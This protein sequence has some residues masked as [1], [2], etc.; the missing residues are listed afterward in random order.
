MYSVNTEAD[1]VTMP[2]VITRVPGERLILTTPAGERIVIEAEPVPAK[3][4]GAV[5]LV[6]DAPREVLVLRH[7]L[8]RRRR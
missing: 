4:D 3:G 8:E 2:L 7:E 1:D 5:R 6:I